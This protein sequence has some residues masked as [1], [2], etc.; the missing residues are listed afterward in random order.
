M[1]APE[2]STPDG[3]DLFAEWL[4]K[5]R[6]ILERYYPQAPCASLVIPVGKGIPDCVLVVTPLPPSSTNPNPRPS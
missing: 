1:S 3:R 6:E 5:G 2:P 4:A